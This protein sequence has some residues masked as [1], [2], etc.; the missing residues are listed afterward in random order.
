MAEF[1]DIMNIKHRMDNYY[2]DCSAGCP[3]YIS[4]F[5]CISEESLTTEDYKEAEKIMLKWAEEHPME[6]PYMIDILQDIFH[7]PR[8]LSIQNIWEWLNTIRI[9]EEVAE[10]L[11]VQPREEY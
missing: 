2:G 1:V 3:L 9:S 5:C 6:Y 8:G 7:M 11:G 10:K 4:N